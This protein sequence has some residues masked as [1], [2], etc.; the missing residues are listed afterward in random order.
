MMPVF[1]LTTTQQVANVVKSFRGRT[2]YTAVVVA[3]DSKLEGILTYERLM[4]KLLSNG[5]GG[6]EDAA[7]DQE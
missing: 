5:D 7:Q 2:E 3:E 6:Y 4:R 1:A